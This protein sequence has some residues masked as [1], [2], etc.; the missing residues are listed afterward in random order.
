MY[1]TK[2]VRSLELVETEMEKKAIEYSRE[3]EAG[4]R[5]L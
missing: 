5:K 2:M 3:W 1:D 4:H